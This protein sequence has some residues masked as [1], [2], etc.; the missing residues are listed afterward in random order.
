MIHAVRLL[1]TGSVARLLV[2]LMGIFLL[3]GCSLKKASE[4][5]RLS[6]SLPNPQRLAQGNSLAALPAAWSGFACYGI[7]VTGPGISDSSRSPKPISN[8]SSFLAGTTSCTYRGVASNGVTF[9]AG[10]ADI[11][12]DLQVPSGPSRVI[13]LVGIMNSAYCSSNFM[14]SDLGSYPEAYE[15]GRATADIFT[16]AS[17]SIT[18][19]YD[20]LNAKRI[21]CGGASAPATIP[22]NPTS[23]SWTQPIYNTT[24]ITANWTPAATASLTNQDVQLFTDST[25]STSAATAVNVSNLITSHIFTGVSDG[26]YYFKVTSYDS[27]PSVLGSTCSPTSTLVDMTAPTVPTITI[28][29]GAA[30]TNDSTPDLTLSVVGATEMYVTN[31]PGCTTGGAWEAYATSKAGWTLGQTNAAA[32]VYVKYRDSAQNETGCVGDTITHDDTAPTGAS[33]TIGY[34]PYTNVNPVDLT[35]TS[36]G[37]TEMYITNTAGCS[38]G[39]SWEPSSTFK[40]NWTLSQMNSTATVYIKFRDVA[41]NETICYSDTII[42]DNTVPLVNILSPATN[43]FVNMTNVSTFSI[44]GT[45]SENGQPVNISGDG[46]G[47]VACSGTTWSTLIDLSSAGEGTVTLNIN[48]SDLAGNFATTASRTFLKDTSPPASVTSISL[49]SPASSPGYID[50]PSF[51]VASAGLTVPDTVKIYRDG[52]CAT[53]VGIASGNTSSIVVTASTTQPPGAATYFARIFDPAGN[54][55]ACSGVSAAYT[56]DNSCDTMVGN[57]ASAGTA[58]LIDTPIRLKACLPIK[59]TVPGT[60]FKMPP[61]GTISLSSITASIPTFQGILD[62]QGTTLTGMTITNGTGLFASIFGSAEVRNLII[63]SPSPVSCTSPNCGFLAAT[64]N[65]QAIIDGV[66]LTGTS[67]INGN[68]YY[69]VGGLV[70]KATGRV[71]FINNLVSGLTLTSNWTG[72]SYEGVGGLVGTFEKNTINAAIDFFRNRVELSQYVASNCGND[73]GGLVGVI[74]TTLASVV[75]NMDQNSTQFNIPSC[76]VGGITRVGGLIGQLYSTTGS[77]TFNIKNSR[78]RGLMNITSS[79]GAFGGVVGNVSLPGSSSVNIDTSIVDSSITITGGTALKGAIV[80][81]NVTAISLFSVANTFWN[82][83]LY[84]GGALNGT[85]GGT[86]VNPGSVSSGYSTIALQ[87]PGTYPGG[88]DWVNVGIWSPA[89]SAIS[90]PK[91]AFEPN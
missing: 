66:Q 73:S 5:S 7:N 32:A 75:V 19:A 30:Y 15:L 36:L 84:A 35:L 78:V 27:V 87:T 46:T 79:T 54:P 33:I 13:Q 43:S 64:V 90:T 18:I 77:N 3:E 65:G 51:T 29:A 60:Y 44:S 70:G 38:A 45:C 57:G 56:Y 50:N 8:F 52:S 69:S 24:S 2:P 20:S 10:Q 31:S 81:Q 67:S 4:G 21:D 37:A 49:L 59:D 82:T 1:L 62:G 55:S 76:N 74:K 28:A 40:S 16:D 80:G 53:M 12:I 63:N 11:A 6:V 88:T 72:S 9:A 83:T 85:S 23:L 17:V 41:D 91:L 61:A 48:H 39:G 58:Y 89:V 22:G 14:Q 68:S 25:C 26:T 34:S 86:Y 47:S 71:Q 42:H